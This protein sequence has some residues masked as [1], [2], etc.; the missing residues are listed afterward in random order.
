MVVKTSCSYP[1]RKRLDK[2]DNNSPL[3]TTPKNIYYAEMEMKLKRK[4]IVHQMHH[5][6]RV[7]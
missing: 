2:S 5:Q 7:E 1:G 6:Y 3:R 4:V